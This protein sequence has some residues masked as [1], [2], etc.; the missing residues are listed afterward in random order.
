MQD[1]HQEK[2]TR[3]A[4]RLLARSP[5][6]PLSLKKKSPPHQVP[7]RKDLWHTDEKLDIGV[8]DEILEIDVEA[9]TCTAEPG[10]TFHRLVRST[11]PLGL[12]PIIVPEHKTITLGGAVAGGSLESKSFQ[13]GGFHD[14][15]LEYELVT[16]TGQVLRCTPT[17]EHALVFQMVHGSFGTLGV[18]T[19]LK[20]RL[21][22]AQPFVRLTYEHHASWD[23]F[24]ASL[25]RHFCEQDVDYLDG[26]V[27]SPQKYVLC[28]G[29]F[30][31]SA[32]YTHRYDWVKVYFQSTARRREDYLTTLDYLFRYDRGVT[33]ANPK[34]AL[35]RAL[36]GRWWH[37]DRVLRWANRL[38]RF[39]PAKRPRVLVDL[40]VPFSRA[41]EF[42]EWYRQRIGVY[43]VWCVPYRRVRDYEWLTSAFF[44]GVHDPLFLD[45]ALYGVRQPKGRN[46]YKELE[47]EL[48]VVNGV[49]T[50]ISYNYYDEE[51]FWR[52]W[53]RPNYEAVK[54]ITDP[55]HVFRDLY[56][57]TCRATRGLE[58]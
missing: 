45:L 56:A 13:Y 36:V 10:V 43:P 47:E 32:P 3:L 15:C 38:H 39:L 7:K 37:S 35:G 40:F 30:V 51:S 57:K 44:A 17:N 8:L 4:Q 2:V 19:R 24:Q 9:R 41:G 29:R 21:I 6:A 46:L 31:S 52:V 27:H 33:T 11:L 28:L 14:T 1:H 53:N 26:M 49:K 16:A 25:W 22:P 23:A 12:V 58:G 50:L 34:S 18:L 48:F 5:S 20:F 55:A 42:L 54:R